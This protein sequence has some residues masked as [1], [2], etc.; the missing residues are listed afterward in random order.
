ML[1]DG[2]LAKRK[3]NRNAR[4]HVRMSFI[5]QN[6]IMQLYQV[7]SNLVQTPVKLSSTFNAKIN[8]EY[9]IWSFMTLSYP[10][11]NEYRELF[12]PNGIKIVSNNIQE[13]LT[14]RGLAQWIMDDGSKDRRKLQV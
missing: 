10:C 2:S 13:L 6:E 5:H 4:Y 11:L 9:K 7:F 14:T 3:E 12:Y 8:K 1:G